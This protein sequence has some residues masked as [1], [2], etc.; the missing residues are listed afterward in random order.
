LPERVLGDWFKFKV[1]FEVFKFV[2]PLG[3]VSAE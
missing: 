2:V 1:V 3:S